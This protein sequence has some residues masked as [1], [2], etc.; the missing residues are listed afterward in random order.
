MTSETIS[1]DVAE[2]GTESLNNTPPR[3][4][5]K[6]HNTI[7]HGIDKH[8]WGIYIGLVFISLI[9]L[10]SASSREV[11]E[12]HILTPLLRHAVLLGVGCIIMLGLQRVNYLKFYRLAW[13]IVILSVVAAI[14][15]LFFGDI[16]NNARRSF[17]I[18]FISIQS[19]ELLKFSAAILI[20][21]VLSVRHT[22]QRGRRC[23]RDRDIYFVAIVVLAFG[24]L[25]I[26][27]GLT[28]TLL[29][30]VI[31]LSM[32]LIAGVRL[33]KFLIV[34]CAYAAL[35]AGYWGYT[36]I[37][38]KLTENDPVEK[39]EGSTD[40]SGLRKKRLENF[41]SN[42]EKYNDKITSENQQEQYSFIAQAN[43][44]M[45]GVGPGNSRETARLP[46]AFSDYIYAI[47]IEDSGFVGG[48]IVMALY[49][50]LL[51]RAGRIASQCRRAF[52]ALLVIGMA[53]F[54]VYQALFHM[55][56]VSGVFPVS[57]QPL[58]F[59]SKGGSS[60]II[61]SVALGIM[62]SVSRSAPRK[63]DVETTDDKAMAANLTQL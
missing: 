62:L 29:L 5:E 13:P 57:G 27:Q 31:A 8:I 15:T 61:S 49:L 25:L 11:T 47:V 2:I 7:N 9:E 37:K 28:N 12:G 34:V 46:L 21:R 53:V 16:I 42:S 30:V 63:N 52:P 18:G 26:K 60:V 45:F 43:G 35:G 51:A 39:M 32:M 56:I 55:A 22:D 24:G 50:F 1:D 14:Y 20:A 38:A 4:G 58:P 41:F 36:E 23:I 17:S 3:K 59:I 48:L 44:G 40:R 33:K 10:Y 6:L 19:S 54:I